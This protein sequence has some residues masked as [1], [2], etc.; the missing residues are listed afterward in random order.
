[1]NGITQILQKKSGLIKGG[2]VR[3]NVF[4]DYKWRVE[5]KNQSKNLI[6][7]TSEMRYIYIMVGQRALILLKIVYSLKN[8]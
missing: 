5:Y 7:K 4:V 3:K 8:M 2:S 1:M 6:S